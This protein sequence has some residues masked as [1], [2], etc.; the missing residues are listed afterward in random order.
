MFK[1][2]YRSHSTRNFRKLTQFIGSS[3]ITSSII[4]AGASAF[5]ADYT[6]DGSAWNPATDVTESSEFTVDSDVTAT[7]NGVITGSGITITK[8]GTGTLQLSGNGSSFQSISM[9][10]YTGTLSFLSG[11]ST[12]IAN[13][14]GTAVRIYKGSTFSIEEGATVTL[15]G[16]EWA[17]DT[18][19]G[20]D[21]DDNSVIELNGGSL[22]IKQGGI[23]H[24]GH[25]KLNGGLLSTVDSADGGTSWLAKNGNKNLG[26]TVGGDVSVQVHD[27]LTVTFNGAFHDGENVGSITKIGAGTMILNARSDF[28]GAMNV[29]D[30]TL[31]LT[32]GGSTG[33]LAAGSTVTVTGA[34]AVLELAN[35]DVLGYNAGAVGTINLENGG[36]MN[37]T[38][39][40]STI[41]AITNMKSGHITGT[42]GND[43]QYIFDNQ[44]NVLSGTDNTISAKTI[45]FRNN[46]N[47][48]DATPGIINVAEGTVLTISSSFRTADS[49]PALQ[50]N[51]TGKL[52]FSDNETG[53]SVKNITGMHINAGTFEVVGGTLNSTGTINIYRTA[54]GTN[55]IHSG[56]TANLYAIDYQNPSGV[57]ATDTAT[58][59][60]SGGTINLSHALWGQDVNTCIFNWE[61]GTLGTYESGNGNNGSWDAENKLKIV[62]GAKKDGV[63]QQ[64]TFN[65]GSGKTVDINCSISDA[66]G[67]TADTAATLTKT[68]AGNL[69]LN[70]TNTFKGSLVIQEGVLRVNT[71]AL[72]SASAITLDG[73]TLHNNGDLTVGENV[74]ITITENDG[75]IRAGHNVDIF[76]NGKITGAGRLEIAQDSADK[77]VVISNS[78]ND[79]TGGT[80]IGGGRNSSSSNTTRVKL[81]AE[82]PLGTGAVEFGANN[83]YLDLAGYN[84]SVKGLD[85]NASHTGI[86]VTNTGDAK[87][88]TLGNG[89]VATDNHSYSGAITEN[90]S[91][92]KIGLGTQTFHN[93][94]LSATTLNITEGTVNLSGTNTQIGTLTT[95]TNG[96][97]RSSGISSISN[98]EMNG[99]WEEVIMS[100]SDFGTISATSLNF[101][102][103]TKLNLVLDGYTP[104]GADTFEIL[105]VTNT[106]GMTD[107][108][109]PTDF[110]WDSILSD[111]Y[112]WNLNYIANATGGSL[113]LSADMNAVPEPTT[114]VLLVL[115]FMGIV[116]A[117]RVKKA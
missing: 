83:S 43:Q 5:G 20:G 98:L 52:V 81:G 50:K 24:G 30:G 40:H 61:D 35:G 18:D 67:V 37:V 102:P 116:G 48:T 38:N 19:G 15:S 100:S 49:N 47:D 97:L 14:D 59:T 9:P 80:L 66:D 33:T 58:I 12:T 114:W 28:T 23:W 75:S 74:L 69:Y 115:G 51:G 85:S 16:K 93:A 84:L 44:I 32:V 68:G 46:T 2:L 111:S 77:G 113:Q 55:Y 7:Y 104:H 53:D 94:D 108:S 78:A 95:G 76:V 110:N 11:S 45:M 89:T 88:L 42:S 13:S 65:V 22:Y 82:N 99:I 36:T 27:G 10:E 112:H 17:F 117:R 64:Q 29:N 91:V 79:Y 87:T 34:T 60:L 105:S 106:F 3:V 4:L 57:T 103:N 107:G 31:R 39:A 90:I 70:A 62:L 54:E 63:T 21:T 86:S 6:W 73:G 8:A 1:F 96:I 92:E 56:G 26:V 71:A 25:L 72:G 41:G 101:N 109:A